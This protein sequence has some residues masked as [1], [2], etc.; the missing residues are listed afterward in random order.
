MDTSLRDHFI[1][2]WQKYFP[3]A[4]LPLALEFRDAGHSTAKKVPP[5]GGWRCTICQIG[6]AR[7]GTPLA[8]D[9][10]SGYLPRRAH[11][12]RVFLRAPAGVPV[13]PLATGKRALWKASGTSRRRRLSMHG[14]N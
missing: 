2:L 10:Q 7:N 1:M 6:Q 3:G 13:F 4:E 5:P 9:G 12:Y 8:F 11:V 14:R